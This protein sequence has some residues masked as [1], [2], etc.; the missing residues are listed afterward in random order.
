MRICIYPGSFDPV[1]NGHLDIIYRAAKQC[2]KLIVAVGNNESKRHAFTLEERVE[3]LK[4]CLHHHP[5]IEVAGFNCLLVD[6]AKEK[7][8]AFIIKGLRAVTDFEYE[9]QMALLNKN[10]CP[11]I[12]TMFMATNINYSYLS[13]S[14][15]RELAKNGGNIDGFVPECIKELVLRKFCP[16]V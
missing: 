3:L 4:S 7:N 1:T 11:D 9:F 16:K 14:V 5:E 8:A 10:L 15:V 12:E 2:D 13:S 6:F